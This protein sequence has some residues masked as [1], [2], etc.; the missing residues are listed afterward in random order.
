M[1]KFE[2]KKDNINFVKSIKSSY[3]LKWVISFLSVKQKLDMI[4]YNKQLQRLFDVD[5]ELYKKISG[6]YKIGDKNGK[7][8][9]YIL[10]TDK[11]IFEGEYKNG[12]RNG[13]GKEYNDY[14]KI[15]FEGEYLNGKRNGKAK[16][17][18][19]NGKILFEG[20][21]LNGKKWN[22]IGYNKY[23]EIDFQIKDGNGKGIEYNYYGNPIF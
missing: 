19:G 11:L 3:I 13:K 5:I 1:D 16:E 6:K 2:G 22:G 17:Y 4:I 15:I 7:G 23:F 8:K 21:Y 10:N 9:E 20:E 12:K 18:F 14:N